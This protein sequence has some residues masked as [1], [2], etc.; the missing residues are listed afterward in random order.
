ML[1][2]L[3]SFWNTES[4]QC[5]NSGMPKISNDNRFRKSVFCLVTSAVPIFIQIPIQHSC[6]KAEYQN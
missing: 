1:K 3:Q 5:T 2:S 4:A 6:Q